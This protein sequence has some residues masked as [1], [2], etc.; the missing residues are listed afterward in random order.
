MT[1]GYDP[2]A[3]ATGLDVATFA[4]TYWG[5][6]PLLRRATDLPSEGFTDLLDLDA[7]DELVSRRG[8]RTPFLRMAK[9]GDVLGSGRFTRGG[10]AGAEI[11]DQAADDKVLAEFAAGATLVL[12]GLHRMWPPVI[13]YAAVLA[14]QLGHPVQVNAYITPS[15]NTGFAPHYDVH[16]VFVLQFAGRK[17][18]RIHEPVLTAPLR[19]QP[20]DARREAVAQR[21]AEE[22]VLDV[23][24][25]PGDALYLPRGYLHAAS[26]LGEVSGHLTIGVQPVTRAFLAEQVLGA[27]SD[28]P[29]LR[30]S[31]PAGADLTDPA[32]LESEL[33]ATRTA[34]HTAIDRLSD[35]RVARAVSGHL[36][37]RTRP[38][39]I[40]PLAQLSAAAALTPS[41]VVRLRA[42]LRYSLTRD[43]GQF[44]LR[45]MERTTTVPARLEPA[46]TRLLGGDP[47]RLADLS[48]LDEA[49][50]LTL[51]RRLLREGIVVPDPR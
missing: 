44:A 45:A 23:V 35:E 6:Q 43:G 42:G 51:V 47:V 34:L 38:A 14:T 20:W 26:A 37:R 12:Q 49:D 10:G 11:S 3:R 28:D 46:L 32:V 27:L 36:E 4:A 19:D 13:D 7:V 15:Q 8:L 2:V 25:E 31:L 40:S 29:E 24:L 30:V 50:A 17:R 5:R 41:D 22:P 48:E 9:E 16:D 18:W 39:P 33:K 1:A 21:A